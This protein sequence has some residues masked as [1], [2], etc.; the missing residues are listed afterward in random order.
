MRRC[1]VF[2]ALCRSV[3]V[4]LHV[5]MACMS[6]LFAKLDIAGSDCLVQGSQNRNKSK[7]P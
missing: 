3:E 7:R 5:K 1:S 4:C 6:E 2:E